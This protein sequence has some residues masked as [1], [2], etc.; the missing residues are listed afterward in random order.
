[1][2][3]PKRVAR[4]AGMF[5]LLTVATAMF[6]QAYVSQRMVV[7]GDAA[8]TAANFLANKGLIRAGYAF[9]LIEMACDMATAVFFYVLLRPVSRPLAL[10][11]LV[12]SLA[13]CAFKTFARVFFILPLF[14]LGGSSSLSAFQPEQLQSLVM[15]LLRI[16]DQGASVAVVF[17]GFA[18]VLRGW[19]V[20]RSGFLPH[21]LGVLSLVSGLGWMTFLYAPLA[22]RTFPVVI[23]IALLGVAAYS[24]WLL[25]FGV[26]E[27]RWHERAAAAGQEIVP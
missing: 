12:L 3:D 21:A 19:L 20:L 13:G 4:M 10:V 23:G 2:T 16:N 25:V 17:F 6:A 1:M 5:S 24:F 8:T 26:D 15:L 11:S 22:S 27:R 14:V 9:Y 18:T 7:P